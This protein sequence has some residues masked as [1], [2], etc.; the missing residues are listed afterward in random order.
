MADKKE[1]LWEAGEICYADG[2]LIKKSEGGLVGSI[3]N[4][5]AINL[6]VALHNVATDINP[7]NPIAVAEELPE[8]IKAFQELT[9]TDNPDIDCWKKA[10]LSLAAITKP[11]NE[12][13][14]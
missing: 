7:S 6:I 8:C 2:F 11:A 3:Y 4:Q 12:E 14:E 10:I 1:Q 5:E 13:G 9:T